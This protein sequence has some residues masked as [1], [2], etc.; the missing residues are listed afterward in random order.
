[1]KELK[2]P[3]GPSSVEDVKAKMQVKLKKIVPFPKWKPS[4]S[5]M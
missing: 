5:V 4:L 2:I 1:M 3:K